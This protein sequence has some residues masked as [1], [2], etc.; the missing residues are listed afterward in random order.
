MASVGRLAVGQRGAFGRGL[1]RHP[2]PPF[3]E[4]HRPTPA[5]IALADVRLISRLDLER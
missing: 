1:V 4:R 2:P 5:L 3:D